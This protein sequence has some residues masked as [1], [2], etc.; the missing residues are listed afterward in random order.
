MMRKKFI[1]H[2]PFCILHRSQM[3]EM[4]NAR[5]DGCRFCRCQYGCLY[6]T[7]FPHVQFTCYE[8]E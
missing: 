6:V 7:M 3:L 2:L 8:L 4:L 5:I 1:T